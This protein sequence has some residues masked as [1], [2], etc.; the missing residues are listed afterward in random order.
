MYTELQ[1]HRR[2]TKALETS[3]ATVFVFITSDSRRR[4][5]RRQEA[6]TDSYTSETNRQMS[7]LDDIQNIR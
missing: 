7:T 4:H 1:I 6:S 2:V 3:T 5:Q